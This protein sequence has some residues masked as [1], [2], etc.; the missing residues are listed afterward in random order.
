ME[1]GVLES[2]ALIVLGPWLRAQARRRP[3]VTWPYVVGSAQGL[4]D[5]PDAADLRHVMDVV[6][7][8]DGIVEEAVPGNHGV[9]ALKL[10]GLLASSGPTVEL[11][12]LYEAGVR[13]ALLDGSPQ[14]VQPY[15]DGGNVDRVV[16]YMPVDGR[17][18]EAL[19]THATR[20]C[21]R[22]I[23]SMHSARSGYSFA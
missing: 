5:V 9:G 23:R 12:A 13:S 2:E 4:T 19:R 8:S 10:D 1:I 7:S 18:A 21:R 20:S 22:D 15:L 14:T 6:L 16:A 3:Y 17:R 11:E